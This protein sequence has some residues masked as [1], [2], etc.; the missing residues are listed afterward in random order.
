[1]SD[2]DDS[3]GPYAVIRFTDEN[4][5]S[6]L[7]DLIPSS[8]I[9]KVDQGYFCSYPDSKDYS[10]LDNWLVSLKDVEEHWDSYAIL[11]HTQYSADKNTLRMTIYIHVAQNIE[12]LKQGKRRLKRALK[13]DDVKSTDDDVCDTNEMSVMILSKDSL[14]KQLN[15]V[16]PFLT[17]DESPSTKTSAENVFPSAS[18]TLDLPVINEETAA[19]ILNVQPI[20]IDVQ[21][22]Y[23]DK[24]FQQ[25]QTEL[26]SQILSAKRSILY[27]L[28]KKITEVKHTIIV[29]NQSNT[30][31]QMSIDKLKEGLNIALPTV[32]LDHFLQL[33][34]LLID[35]PEKKE[36]LMALFRVLIAAEPDLKEGI[37][38]AMSS[39]MTKTVELQYSATG[40]MINGQSERNFSGTNSSGGDFYNNPR[41][42]IVVK[43]VSPL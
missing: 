19:E 39:I 21:I 30:T 29:N 23:M 22:D 20:S 15:A 13:S 11:L 28:D 27:D 17:I 37:A 2:Q 40:R 42:G 8:W 5:N 3:A 14:E 25:L 7:I 34:N 36:A 16:K 10:H 12:N 24:K 33:E 1:M 18:I 43:I 41:F 4:S 6:K 35:S 9:R 31:S 32:S 38:K 26:S